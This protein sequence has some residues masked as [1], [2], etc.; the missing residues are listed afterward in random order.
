MWK[1]EFPVLILNSELH[2]EVPPLHF[3]SL[4]RSRDGRLTVGQFKPCLDLGL[5]M[6]FF[7]LDLVQHQALALEVGSAK[8]RSG[9]SIV[10]TC[11]ANMRSVKLTEALS[12]F[13]DVGSSGGD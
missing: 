12:E 9:E 2:L 3:T 6:C 5:P 11:I 13:K 4:S 8:I 10:H 7:F 1:S